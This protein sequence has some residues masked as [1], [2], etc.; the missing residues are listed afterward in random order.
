MLRAMHVIV[1]GRV[2]GVGFR[3]FVADAARSE[4]LDGW[5]KNLP[6]GSVEVQAEGDVEAL[7][8]LEWKLWQGPPMSRVDEVATEDVVPTGATGFRIA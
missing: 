4:G 6:D 3:A 5:V 7:R 1:S 2:Q 8:R